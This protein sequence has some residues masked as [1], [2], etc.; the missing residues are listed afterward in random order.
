MSPIVHDL[1]CRTLFPAYAS[2]IDELNRVPIRLDTMRV[3]DYKIKLE[4]QL[5]KLERGMA[6]FSR[7][8]VYVKLP[9]DAATVPPV[10]A[11]SRKVLT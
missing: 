2:L 1:I 4:Q 5:Q 6:I 11:N 8:R 10:D 3:R 9:Q 7:P